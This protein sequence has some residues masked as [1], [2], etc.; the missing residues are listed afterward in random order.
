LSCPAVVDEAIK[1]LSN[2]FPI[3][4]GMAAEL[5]ETATGVKVKVDGLSVEV[6]VILAS[7]GR[8]PNIDHLGLG[9][10]GIKLNQ[11]G[12]PAFNVN[13]MQIQDLPIFIAGDV[14]GFSPHFCTKQRLRG[15]WLC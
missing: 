8:R 11:R 15:K 1:I 5:E 9:V 2:E 7:L 6:D 3:Y 4:L 12:M 10:A 14:N 13:T